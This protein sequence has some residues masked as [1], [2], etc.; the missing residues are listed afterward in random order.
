MS[1]LRARE[2]PLPCASPTPL[3]SLPRCPRHAGARGRVRVADV[4]KDGA[5]RPAPARLGETEARGK[6]DALP[7]L[8][9]TPEQDPGTCSF[10][11]WG[12]A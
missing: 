7:S 3:E 9:V 12:P 10:R 8:K 2:G 6:E 4:N 5:W 1:P 11:T